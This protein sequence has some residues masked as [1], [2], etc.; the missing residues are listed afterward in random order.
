[1]ASNVRPGNSKPL[2]PGPRKKDLARPRKPRLSR[3]K[4]RS[5]WF[6]GRSAWPVRE[7]PG[8]VVGGGGDWVK[9]S[10]GGV[11]GGG[12]WGCVGPNNIGGRMTSIVCH[13]ERP[14]CIWAGAACGGVW[15]SNDA[16]RTW[17]S[18]WNDHDS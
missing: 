14:D 9:E 15:Q 16:G 12:G 7:A 6:Q 2:K 5:A 4:R 8:R 10:V 18:V 3:H 13:P 1:M 17:H 11:A